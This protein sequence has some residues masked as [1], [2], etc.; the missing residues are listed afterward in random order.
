M[1]S[2]HPPRYTIVIH[3]SEIGL[4]GGNRPFFERVL[5]ENI[6]RKLPPTCSVSLAQKRLFVECAEETDYSKARDALEKVFGIAWFAGAFRVEPTMEAVSRLIEEKGSILLGKAKTFRI[7]ASRADK[8]FPFT[9]NE[10]AEKVGKQVEDLFRRRVELR[11]PGV[12]IYIEV[13]PRAVYIFTEKEKGLRGLPAGSSGKVLSL[14]SGGIDSPVASWL[15]MRRGCTVDYIHFHA[16]RSREEIKGSKIEKL[17]TTLASFGG[18]QAVYLVPFSEF[19]ARILDAD[20]RY[21]LLL[22]RR[23]IV[24]LSVELAKKEG[25]EALVMGDSVGQ[26]AS[27]TL[28]YLRLTDRDIALPILRPLVGHTKEEITDLARKIGTYEVSIEGYKDCC[29]IV[30]A[31]PTLNPKMNILERLEEKIDLDGIVEKTLGEIARES[32]FSRKDA[33]PRKI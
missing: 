22:F 25:H 33:S 3:Y 28:P 31:H 12:A 26:V 32:D 9:S 13:L 20:P 17:I 18:N 8:S 21:E 5:K 10:I 15:M 2:N 30:S 4:K 14:F 11:E 23:F 7:T 27:Q 19:H 29:S 1:P 16:L 6:E 24:K